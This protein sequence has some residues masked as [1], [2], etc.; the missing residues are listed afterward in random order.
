MGQIFAAFLFHLR[1][2]LSLV[3]IGALLVACTAA[4]LRPS[5]LPPTI[6][7]ADPDTNLVPVDGGTDCSRSHV[8]RVAR[9][10]F[11]AYNASDLPTLNKLFSPRPRF[12][13]YSHGKT[14]VSQR[15][16]LLDYFAD[17][18]KRPLELRLLDVTVLKD[19]GWHGGFDFAFRF[20]ERSDEV[21]SEPRL[22]KGAADCQIYV[23]SAGSERPTAVEA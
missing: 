20:R 7:S 15:S 17:E 9:S 14:L 4:E 21:W 12:R 2:T 6:E 3:A 1:Q 11:R 13:W 22:G 16:D 5:E 8:E 10:F 19:R 18:S 23:W